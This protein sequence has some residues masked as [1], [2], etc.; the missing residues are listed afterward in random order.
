M[1][2]KLSCFS[3]FAVITA[4]V[5][6]NALRGAPL[7]HLEKNFLEVSS[8]GE[9]NDIYYSSSSERNAN[10]GGEDDD[11]WE[12]IEPTGEEEGKLEER[13]GEGESVEEETTKGE[14][15]K[16]GI[17]EGEAKE[18]EETKEHQPQ[19]TKKQKVILLWTSW[20]S[21]STFLGELLR[22]VSNKTFYS[23]EPLHMYHINVFDKKENDDTLIPPVVLLRDLLSCNF[24][25][26]S[27]LVKYQKKKRWYLL[28][29]KYLGKTC[30]RRG[31]L[32]MKVDCSSPLYVGGMCR[33]ANVHLIKV[34]RLSLRW[35]RTFLENKS[36]DFQILYLARDPRAVLSSRTKLKWCNTPMCRNPN[37]TCS[38]LAGDLAEASGLQ[39]EFPERFKFL[40][41]DK[42]CQDMTTSLADI[43]NFLG[44]PVQQEQIDLLKFKET[45]DKKFSIFKNSL[46]QAQLWRSNTPFQGIVQPV[47]N[48][49]ESSLE[50]LGLRIFQT[51]KELLD[52]SVPVLERPS[53]L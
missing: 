42:I 46:L 26:H 43:M 35:A 49:C 40:H 50:K 44:L 27:N 4:L 10:Y 47:Q 12:V 51:E 7:W 36:L 45:S 19:N 23:Y 52:L 14:K 30:R 13:M 25:A 41:Y 28:A 39:R 11:H 38:H 53:K 17:T 29:N 32:G 6:L 15:G 18:G 16:E 2:R 3:L 8:H 1:G 9:E 24:E 34:L 21:G 48:S 20:R 5:T 37:V 22:R 31:H 33:S